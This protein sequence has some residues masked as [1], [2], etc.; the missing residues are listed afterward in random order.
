MKTKIKASIILCTLNGGE[1]ITKTIESLLGQTYPPDQYEIIAVNDG[2]TDKTGQILSTYPIKVLHHPAPKGIAHARNTGLKHAK[3]EITVCFDDDCTA[4]PNWLS[5]LTSAFDDKNVMGVGSI[6]T[7]PKRPSLTDQYCFDTGYGN[8]FPMTLSRSKN[9]LVRLFTY[10]VVNFQNPVSNY[11]NGTTVSELPGIS[12]AFR[13][14]H[15]KLVGGWAEQYTN[16]SEDIEICTRLKLKFPQK[17]F[18]AATEAKL[19]HEQHLTFFNFIKKEFKR[20]KA[21]IQYYRLIDK[22]PPYFPGPLIIFLLLPFMAT[23][24]LALLPHLLYPWWVVRTIKERKIRMLIYP[25]L[26]LLHE[27]STVIGMLI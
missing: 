18:I 2:S 4:Y 7:L 23:P 3:G 9:I 12:A 22:T 15:L 25:Y 6:I 26:Q 10:I 16:C 14:D 8:P 24:T 27:G 19:V 5:N 20:G 17:K 21:R 11:E 13:T 1:E